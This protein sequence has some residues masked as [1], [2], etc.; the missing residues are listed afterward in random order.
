MACSY[1]SWLDATDE[2]LGALTETERN[3]V[4]RGNATR[5]YNLRD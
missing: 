1:E 5:A 4:L 3:A 2:L